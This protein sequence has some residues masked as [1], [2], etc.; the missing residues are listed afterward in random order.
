M[1]N[2]YNFVM[3]G[4]NYNELFEWFLLINVVTFL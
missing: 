4:Y 2:N 3:N 1:N